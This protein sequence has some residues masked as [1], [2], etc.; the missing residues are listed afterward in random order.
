M[1]LAQFKIL[2]RRE[3]QYNEVFNRFQYVDNYMPPDRPIRIPVNYFRDNWTSFRRNSM[4]YRL[5][6]D[7]IVVVF[8]INCNNH[9]LPLWPLINGTIPWNALK[10]KR[11]AHFY[12][13]LPMYTQLVD[14]NGNP[15]D[16]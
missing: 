7:E 6:N 1:R 10:W 4:V 11:A 9:F 14:L 5:K 8:T 15:L 12:A 2:P 13:Y 3:Y 16:G